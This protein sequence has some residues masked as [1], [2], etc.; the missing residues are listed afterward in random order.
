[1]R[2]ASQWFMV[3]AGKFLKVYSGTGRLFESEQATRVKCNVQQR[4]QEGL[5]GR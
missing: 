3:L 5:A 2:A 4:N 1:M